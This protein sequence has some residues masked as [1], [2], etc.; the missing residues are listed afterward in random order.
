VSPV[1]Y[2]LASYIPEDDVLHSYVDL[3]IASNVSVTITYAEIR[4]QLGN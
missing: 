1:K 3:W 4:E 2:E